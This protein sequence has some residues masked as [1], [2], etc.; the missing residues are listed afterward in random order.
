[1]DNAVDLTTAEENVFVIVE[2]IVTPLEELTEVHSA[3]NETEEVR[4]RRESRE[5]LENIIQEAR[6]NNEQEE[7]RIE[8]EEEIEREIRGEIDEVVL[9]KR[10]EA[11]A[12]AEMEEDREE[13][14]RNAK[15]ILLNRAKAVKRQA[16]NAAKMI[17]DSNK[18]FKQCKIND[19]VTLKVPDVDKRRG[20]FNNAMTR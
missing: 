20:D 19:S 2:N 4:I 8:E 3:P 5:D 10:W 6:I 11:Q 7:N 16:E 13:L 17:N 18:K 12:E 15:N 14:A 9:R 1:M